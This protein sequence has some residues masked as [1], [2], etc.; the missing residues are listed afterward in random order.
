MDEFTT[1][2]FTTAPPAQKRSRARQA[3]AA[4]MAIPV[5]SRG[6]I[7]PV[8][9]PERVGTAREL[10]HALEYLEKRAFARPTVLFKRNA[11]WRVLRQRG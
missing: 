8:R 2:E 9:K 1:D 7:L 6:Q 3:Y 11:V 4:S 10:L 5:L